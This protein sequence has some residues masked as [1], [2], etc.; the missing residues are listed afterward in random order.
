MAPV[1]A[2]IA[3]ITSHLKKSLRTRY[4]GCK[5]WLAMHAQLIPVTTACPK[6]PLPHTLDSTFDI[7]TLLLPGCLHAEFI[8]DT[9]CSFGHLKASH[10]KRSFTHEAY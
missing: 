2:L 8:K 3:L 4:V 9:W 10:R 7:S 6:D 1:E 5:K